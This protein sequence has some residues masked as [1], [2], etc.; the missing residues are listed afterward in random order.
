MRKGDKTLLNRYNEAGCSQFGLPV[1]LQKNN[2]AYMVYSYEYN[3][4]P[5]HSYSIRFLHFHRE[6]EL[7]LCV[8]GS[9]VCRYYN[10]SDVTVNFESGQTFL[11]LPYQP[12]LHMT[13]PEE[14]CVMRFLSLDPYR[15]AESAGVA[16]F[17]RLDALLSC[18][19]TMTGAVRDG[20][21]DG[22]IKSLLPLV[23]YDAP[24]MKELLFGALYTVFGR[25][26]AGG[27]ESGGAA[28]AVGQSIRNREA[29]RLVSPALRQLERCA[30]PELE[31]GS[32]C[33]DEVYVSRLAK[34]CNMS[35]SY[36]RRVFRAAI[37]ETPQVYVTRLKLR[38]ASELL[39]KTSLP[40]TEVGLRSGF[41]DTTGFYRAFLRYRGIS[42][43]EYRGS[44]R[45]EKIGGS[46]DA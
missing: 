40:V 7:G 2:S 3:E 8:S 25:V 42:P 32:I 1:M 34:L 21:L 13:S 26:S 22:Y 38:Y 27:A 28:D 18:G 37:G 24:G 39:R 45:R 31:N 11:F 4:H 16:D 9:G 5:L 10:G 43:S 23:S 35:E 46:S 44:R 30:L 15:L 41:R 19:M 29:I 12:H 14:P 36:F 33:C 20:F 17:T 6:L